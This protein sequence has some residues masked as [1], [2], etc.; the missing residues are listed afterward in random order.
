[1]FTGIVQDLVTVIG[2]EDEGDLSRIE[3]DMKDLA[4]GI[5]LGAS[6]AVNGTCLTVT[7]SSDK[8]TVCFSIFVKCFNL[9]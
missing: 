4:E 9:Y 8:G 2:I 3:L 7:R 1:M 6:V 5:E